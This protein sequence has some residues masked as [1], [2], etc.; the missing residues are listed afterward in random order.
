M[1]DQ[2]PAPAWSAHPLLQRNTLQAVFQRQG[3][4]EAQTEAFGPW[5]FNPKPDP[6]AGQTESINEEQGPVASD[7][8]TLEGAGTTD[9]RVNEPESEIPGLRQLDV[10]LMLEQARAESWQ[11]GH[12]AAIQELTS[13]LDAQRLA[14][15]AVAQALHELQSDPQRWFE[16]L[17]K[18]SIHIAQEL[19]RGEMQLGSTVIERLIQGCIEALDQ[20]AET[21]LIQVGHADMHRLR[22]LNLPGISLEL[23]ESLSE[24]SVRAK[25]ND[26]QVQ[27]LIEHRLAQMA[28]QILQGNA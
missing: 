17:K 12:D 8:I 9:A 13:G 21:T 6:L 7:V 27:D 5:R 11:L 15:Q 4:D 19:V 3:W 2:T 24:G 14:L 28:Q 1:S 26:T 16:P 18:L 25:V 10:D 20:P 23:D 22:D